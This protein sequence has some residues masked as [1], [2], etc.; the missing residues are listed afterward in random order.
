[1]S[2]S[3]SSSMIIEKAERAWEVK[4]PPTKKHMVAGKLMPTVRGAFGFAKKKRRLV[5]EVLGPGDEGVGD[6]GVGDEG[7]PQQRAERSH[8]VGDLCKLLEHEEDRVVVRILKPR[9]HWGLSRDSDDSDDDDE[10]GMSDEVRI[11][12]LWV[13]VVSFDAF[14]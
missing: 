5:M 4:L 2:T 1:M 9:K 14:R 6:E 7:V 11:T 13:V 12:L 3:N 8:E 10:P